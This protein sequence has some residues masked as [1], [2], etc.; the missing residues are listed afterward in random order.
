MDGGTPGDFHPAPREWNAGTAMILTRRKL[1]DS[2]RAYQFVLPALVFFAAFIVYPLI[3]VFRSSLNEVNTLKQVSRFIG[4]GNFIELS[5]DAVFW[6]ALLNTFIYAV[7]IIVLINIP[8]ISFAIILD[9]GKVKGNYLLRVVLF[10][11]AILAPVLVGITFKRIFAP[12]GALNLILEKL[13]LVAWQQN[14]LGEPSLALAAVILTTVWQ[15]VGWNMVLYYAR[16]REIPRELYEAAAIDGAS[17]TGIVRHIKL[18]LMREVIAIL[19]V[20]N[21]I[22]GFKVFDLIFIMTRGGPAHKTEVLT[23]FLFYQAFDFFN[24]GYSSSV[25]VVLFLI[26]LFFSWLRIS[27]AFKD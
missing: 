17:E 11:P 12:T 24:W 13:G 20:I 8:A 7:A 14:W 19:V 6:R 2:V 5:Q 16:L 1:R 3:M 18:P 10:A 21:I 27:T 9:R 23:S 25:A 22:G 15:S 4:L 26:V